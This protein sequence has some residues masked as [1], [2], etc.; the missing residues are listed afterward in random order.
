MRRM[1]SETPLYTDITINV[2]ITKLN[3]EQQILFH[4]L[5]SSNPEDSKNWNVKIWDFFIGQPQ[6][7]I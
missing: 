1:T 6:V 4:L 2:Y 3:N 5:N 7:N